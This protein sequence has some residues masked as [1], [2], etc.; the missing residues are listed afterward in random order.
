[1]HN[2]YTNIL[3]KPLIIATKLIRLSKDSI[4]KISTFS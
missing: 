1:M 2:D 4:T 3:L